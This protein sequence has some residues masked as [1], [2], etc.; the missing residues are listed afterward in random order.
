MKYAPPIGSTDPNQPYVDANPA[1]GIQG[2]AVPAAAIEPSMREI[3]ASIKA[4]MGDNSPS[5]KDNEQLAKALKELPFIADFCI[6]TKKSA[7]NAYILQPASEILKC[8]RNYIH[9]MRIRFKVA[10]PNSA[11]ATLDAYGLGARP[12]K[13]HAMTSD[14]CAGDFL[15]NATIELRFDST[16]GLEGGWE[17]ISTSHEVGAI[18]LYDFQA[19][20]TPCIVNTDKKTCSIKE[21]TIIRLLV[22]GAPRWRQQIESETF[23]V[24][25][26]LDVGKTLKNGKDYYIYLAPA[27]TN[28]T[29]FIVS[30]NSTYPWG[31][32]AKNTRKIGGFH[33]LC[34]D[35]GTIKDHPLSGYR[36][37]DILPSSVW[38]LNHRPYSSPEGMVYEPT[39]NIWVDIYMQSGTNENTRSTYSASVTTLR[40]YIDHVEDMFRV[41]KA[42]LSDAEFSAAMEGSNQ[43]TNIF[44]SSLPTPLTSGGHKDT[45]YRRMISNIGCEEGCGYLWTFL[46][47]CGGMFYGADWTRQAGSKGGIFNGACALL[48]GGEWESGSYAGSR[49]RYFNLTRRVRWNRITARGRSR[50]RNFI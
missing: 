13:K 32:T 31:C 8:Y 21:G 39:Q 10:N 44:G 5:A 12:I 34:A 46:R 22:D 35:V 16:Y 19:W 47:E 36:A 28:G 4:L 26:L 17:F 48:A 41:N 43:Q 9:G 40:E 15:I 38:C 33:T 7:P 18:A 1:A 42:L 49:S 23:N 14:L 29:K 25:A 30:E 24:E 20:S 3:E 27:G 50:P 2:S 37:G 11:A 6:E 45:E